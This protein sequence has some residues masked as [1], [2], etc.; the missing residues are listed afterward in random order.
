MA[1]THTIGKVATRVQKGDGI[2]RVTYHSTDVVTVYPNGKIVLDSGGWRTN[3]TKLRMNQASQ[4]LGLGFNVWQRLGNW[5]VDIDG[6]VQEF[7][8]GKAI[9]NGRDYS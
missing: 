1:Q 5:Y 3:T 6:T 8:D 9:R 4:E 2:T 7:E